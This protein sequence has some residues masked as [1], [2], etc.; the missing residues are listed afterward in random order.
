M[1][2]STRF[3]KTKIAVRMEKQ[4]KLLQKKITACW[5]EQGFDRSQY[6]VHAIL[7]LI[8]IYNNWK[9]INMRGSAYL[10]KSF[11]VLIWR[12]IFLILTLIP[13]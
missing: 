1:N 4:K 8:S 3:L 2:G 6:E 5:C 7:M 9:H 12:I 13:F 10:S 11:A